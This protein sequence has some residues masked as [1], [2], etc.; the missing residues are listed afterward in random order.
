MA[1]SL[2][3]L[4]SGGTP[5]GQGNRGAIT[6]YVD[7]Q[8]QFMDELELRTDAEVDHILDVYCNEL[9]LNQVCLGPGYANQYD[10]HDRP[11]I[12][13]TV[14]SIQPLADKLANRGLAITLA[15]LPDIPPYF[16]GTQWNLQLLEV[17]L[18]PIYE[19]LVRQGLI[20]AVRLEWET[21]VSSAQMCAPVVWLR[22]F[23]P[24]EIP[25]FYHNPVNPGKHLSPCLS[26]EPEEWGWRQFL[27]AGGSGLDMQSNTPYSA[28]TSERTPLDQMLYDLWDMRRRAT[29]T[30]GSPWGAP[31]LTLQGMPM[32]VRNAEYAAYDL[33]HN[34]L[35]WATAVA[36]GQAG[37]TVVGPGDDTAL[38]GI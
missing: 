18:R 26:S 15:A 35:P 33:T 34:N 24:I 27:A 23:V 19:S 20:A 8:P 22:Q 11:P 12:D 28:P 2:I 9:G 14:N 32:T 7:G 6:I 3:L 10:H 17:N 5:V 31:L 37:L 38:D 4:A 21:C 13:W 16:D 29:G 36:Y 1:D 25:I 30:N